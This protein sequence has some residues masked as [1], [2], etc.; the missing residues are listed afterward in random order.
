MA[1][2]AAATLVREAIEAHGGVS[3]WN[4]LTALEAEI[5]AWGFLFTVKRRPALHHIRVWA[6]T[7]EPHFIFR[8]F[9]RQGLRAELI[10][11]QEVRLLD[12]RGE[13]LE[14]RA[15]PRR[16]FRTL[17][18]QFSWDDLDFTYFAGYATWNYLVTPFLFLRPGFQLELVE[19]SANGAGGL[20]RVKATFPADFPTHCR[21]Q[22]FYFDRQRLLRR[23]DYTAE[24]VGR[25]ARAAHLCDGYRA[26]DGL[27]APTR[28]RVWP[29]P[30]GTEPIRFPTL[31]AIDVHH[32]QPQRLQ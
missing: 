1:D 24:V 5:S 3:M 17:R 15:Q 26:F 31:V 14:R 13:V 32:L 9:P 22:T 12:D 8:D 10:G 16:A 27:K 11:D 28:R 6:S 19:P 25:W 7:R 20:A 18:R 2:E 4:A 29:L 21:T 30:F 23:L